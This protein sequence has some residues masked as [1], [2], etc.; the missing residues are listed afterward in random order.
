[1]AKMYRQLVQPVAGYEWSARNSSAA[2]LLPSL[3]DDLSSFTAL[4]TL[5][6][7]ARPRKPA[8][9]IRRP[10]PPAATKSLDAQ[11]LLYLTGMS[12]GVFAG[13]TLGLMACGLLGF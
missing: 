8:T 4:D 5:A 12:F 11:S 13:T 10:A 2:A 1:M 6:A 3:P 9:A 7:V